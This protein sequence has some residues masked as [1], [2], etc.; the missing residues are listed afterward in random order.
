MKKK[1][2][3]LLFIITLLGAFLRLNQFSVSPPSLY[4]DEADVGYQA[5]SLITTGRDYFGNF[6]P[7]HL[8]SFADFRTPLYIYT[9]IPAILI[10]GLSNFAVRIPAALFGILTIPLLFWCTRNLMKL[11]LQKEADIIALLSAFIISILPWH[12]HYS[13]MA[14]EVTLLLFLLVLGLGFFSKWIENKKYYYFLFSILALITTLYTYSTAKLFTPLLLVA[15]IFIGRKALFKFTKLQKLA[16]ATLTILAIVPMAKDIL[17]GQGGS[18]FS[19]LSVFADK[20]SIGPFQ[21]LIWLSSHAEP[22]LPFLFIHPQTISNIFLSTS[23]NLFYQIS[24]TYLSVFSPQFLIFSGDPNLRQSITISGVAGLGITLLF[25]VGLVK[26]LTSQKNLVK[27]ILLTLLFLSPLPAAITRDGAYHATRLFIFILPFVIITA[28]GVQVILIKTRHTLIL[29]LLCFAL[30]SLIS[31]ETFRDQFIRLAVYPQTSYQEWNFGWQENVNKSLSLAPQY[32]EVLIDN[33]SGTP[34]QTFYAFYNKI[35][36]REFQSF[37]KHLDYKL[38]IPGITV[39]KYFK[40]NISF[41]EVDPTWLDKPLPKKILALVPV[42]KMSQKEFKNV[43][44]VD[45]VKN[46]WGDP[47][48]YFITNKIITR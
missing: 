23:A 29:V 13:R 1:T 8:Q 7:I 3:V 4:V 24:N 27:T 39:R 6:M 15:L 19:I 35:E 20:N 14:Y 28:L 26:I 12:I 22:Y 30:I 10:F 43:Q 25:F 17:F 42:S 5:Y 37:A 48:Y 36:P 21:H 38:D 47:L 2:L 18:R 34:V 16:A 41:T 32:D 9:T 33:L 11:Y 40:G 45:I 46:P 44:N 31:W